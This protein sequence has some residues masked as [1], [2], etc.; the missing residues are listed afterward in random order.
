MSNLRHL[1]RVIREAS[2]ALQ[3]VSEA[4]EHELEC[5]D[6]HEEHEHYHHGCGKH[7]HHHRYCCRK[8]PHHEE[9][10]HEEH[11][12]CREES[13]H[14]ED[15]CC[16]CCCCQ[17]SAHHAPYPPFP[18]YP[19]FAPYPPMPPYPPYP[20]YPPIII[21]G[22]GCHH[23]GHTPGVTV[24]AVPSSA[25]PGQPGGPPATNVTNPAYSASPSEPAIVNPASKGISSATPANIASGSFPDVST[26]TNFDAL[27][28]M[29]ESVAS[30]VRNAIPAQAYMEEPS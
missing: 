17:G 21:S 9:R 10:E 26:I 18:P 4:V 28:S 27:L 5:D 19:P 24:A 6:E 14:D 7:Y 11:D 23:A 20:P 16:C 29:A 22:C 8:G 25:M 12:C 13:E 30:Q 1:R 2:E 15:C 3:A